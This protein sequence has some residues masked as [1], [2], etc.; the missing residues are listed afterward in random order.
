MDMSVQLFFNQTSP[1][2]RKARVAVHEFGLAQ[3]V[4]CVETDPWA[5]PDD[6][7]AVNP[8]SKVPV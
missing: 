8:L 5:E 6:L 1:Y 4:T 2:A 3:H 7:T